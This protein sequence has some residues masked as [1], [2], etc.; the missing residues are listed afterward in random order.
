MVVEIVAIG[1][2]VGVAY[3][4]LRLYPD[5]TKTWFRRIMTARQIIGGG[6]LLVVGLLFIGSGAT[7]LVLAGFA[8]LLYA[9]LFLLLE[10]PHATIV[11]SVKTALGR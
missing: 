10:K 2:A 4:L 6:A 11:S 5:L 9:A 7:P 8:I 1:L 3:G